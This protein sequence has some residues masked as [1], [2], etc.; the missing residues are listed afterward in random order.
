MPVSRVVEHLWC[1]IAVWLHH[2]SCLRGPANPIRYIG[3]TALGVCLQAH[4]P[5][6]QAVEVIAKV[7]VV[8]SSTGEVQSEVGWTMVWVLV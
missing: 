1:V 7:P 8:L 4:F 3:K 5:M 2:A 6:T